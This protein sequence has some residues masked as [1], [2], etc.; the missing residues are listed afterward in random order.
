MVLLSHT[1]FSFISTAQGLTEETFAVISFQ[2]FEGLSTLYEFDILLVS[3]NPSIDLSAIIQKSAR[4]VIQED[5]G[6][7]IRFYG[8]LRHFEQLH[9]VNGYY[10]YRALLSPRLWW[11]TQN[12]YNQVF[13]NK[14]ISAIMD[15]ILVSGGLT[16][17]DYTLSLIA[18]YPEM[19]YVCQYGESH[20]N[21]ISRWMEREGIYYYFKQSAS[22]ETV[23]FTDTRITHTDTPSGGNL[24]YSPPSG[25]DSANQ[26]LN[27]QSFSCRQRQ[28][29]N[30]VRLKDYNYQNPSLDIEG[31][32]DVDTANGHGEVYLYGDHFLTTEEGNRLAAIRAGELLCRQQMFFG[33]STVP[34]L[35]SGYTFTLNNHFRSSFNKKYLVTEITHQGNQTGYLISGIQQVLSTRE[36]QVF[37][38]NSFTAIPASAQ[39]RPERKTGK[40]HVSGTIH[41]KIDA[42]GDGKFAELDTKG[43]YKVRLPFDIDTAHT[44]G[45]ASSFVRMAQPYAGKPLDSSSVG[46]HFPLHKDTEVLLTFIDGDPDRPVIA[47]AVP[48][49][50][51]ESPVIAKNQTQ[52]VF[53]DNFGNELVF[54]ST[55]G[56]EFIKLSSPHNDSELKLGE[57]VVKTTTTD[58]F[59]WTAGNTVSLAGGTKYEAYVGNS[60][61]TNAGLSGSATFGL[62][63]ELEMAGKHSFLLGYESGLNIGSEFTYR[64][65]QSIE[66]IDTDKSSIAAGDNIIS[67]QKV[68]N[69][70]GGA[71]GAVPV[72]STSIATLDESAICLTV[73]KNRNPDSTANS[74]L[75]IGALIA[76]PI[77]STVLAAVLGGAMAGCLET[78]DEGGAKAASSAVVGSLEGVVIFANIVIMV[79]L[80]QFGLKDAVNPVTHFDDPA[81]AIDSLVKLDKT[82]GV[83]I[84][85]RPDVTASIVN[86]QMKVNIDG[87][88]EIN[89]CPTADDKNKIA[90]GVGNLSAADDAQDARITLQKTGSNIELRSGKSNMWFKKDGTI[91]TDTKGGGKIQL[92]AADDVQLSS[93]SGDLVFKAKSVFAK[94][95]IFESKN[96]KDLG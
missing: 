82:N 67:A 59:E 23:V 30:R 10:F 16:I 90:I 77:I 83:L 86:A 34:I 43:R 39:F 17:A 18:A 81:D 60:A 53:R 80:A 96:I 48:N 19:E 51:T 70:V 40:P 1:K 38:R 14:K 26:G 47:G 76:T 64:I 37:Y 15:S 35:K 88:I 22:G 68:V 5:G 62:S 27:I 4:L 79:C 61:E 9:G 69:L 85:T 72:G 74:K 41:A 94:K 36:S 6:A 71:K 50:A 92:L 31:S 7:D 73:G 44:A 84:A 93:T 91:T 55:T 54:D 25:T 29:P 8:I 78:P 75:V 63:Y 20:F 87:T 33:E 57:D 89:S 2:G 42:E 32:A 28:L 49:T 56:K 3:E 13:L 46:L 21:F 45:K 24:Y 65:G 58:S 95:G 12:N 11:L 52:S 66:K